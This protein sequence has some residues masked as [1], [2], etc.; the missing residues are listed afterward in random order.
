[1]SS[2]KEIMEELGIEPVELSGEEEEWWEEN[3]E[4]IQKNSEEHVRIE[5]G[6]S[7]PLKPTG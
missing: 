1:M 7:H 2:K 3:K 4:R 6:G 5:N